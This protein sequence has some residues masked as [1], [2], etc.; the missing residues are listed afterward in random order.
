MDKLTD[1]KMFVKKNPSLLSFV[2]E[3]SMTWQKFYE[4]FDLYG[5]TNSVWQPYLKDEIVKEATKDA[6][7]GTIDWVSWFKNIDMD[8]MQ[9]GIRS[10]ER[11]LSV[12]KDFGSNEEQ[13][14]TYEPRPIYKHF[15]D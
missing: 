9:E 4:I 11:V 6:T 7:L 1:F 8:K 14:N 10:V 13:S 3:G 15:E 12:L 5:E 2:N